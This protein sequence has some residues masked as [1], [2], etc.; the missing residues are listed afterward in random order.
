MRLVRWSLAGVVVLLVGLVFVWTAVGHRVLLLRVYSWFPAPELLAPP[1]TLR[2]GLAWHDDYYAIERLDEATWAIGEPRYAQQ[3]VSYLIAGRERAVLFDAGPGLRELAPVVAGLTRL[4]ITFVPSHLH[5]DHVGGARGFERVALID[6]PALREQAPDGVLRPRF[7]QHLG[8]LEGIEARPLEV[9]EWWAPGSVVDLGGRALEVW[10]T[11]GHT[12]ESASLLDRARG[13]LFSGDYLYPGELYAFLPGSSLADY[14]WTAER[15]TPA[16]PALAAIHGGHGIELA[17]SA[18]VLAARDL[19]DLQRAL[20]EIRSGERGGSGW[21]PRAYPVNERLTL[22]SDG[23]AGD[24]TPQ[25][26]PP[27]APSG[28]QPSTSPTAMLAA[29]DRS[30][31]GHEAASESPA[32]APRRRVDR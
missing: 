3:N 28:G 24:W 27:G 9:D 17:T 19:L 23:L 18:P 2:P 7:A 31:V 13:M 15:L 16:L 32:R 1:G 26:R 30:T 4:P 5:Y 6:L 21:F 20:R 22:L 8:A 25:A 14:L 10:H 11:P 29:A 12:P